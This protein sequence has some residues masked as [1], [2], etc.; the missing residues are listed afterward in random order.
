M[1]LAQTSFSAEIQT[2]NS[3]QKAKLLELLIANMI[4]NG[5]G[6]LV[7]DVLEANKALTFSAQEQMPDTDRAEAETEPPSLPDSTAKSDAYLVPIMRLQG[8]AE[9]QHRA[10][11]SLFDDTPFG[12]SNFR[13]GVLRNPEARKL[14]QSLILENGG[15]CS[16]SQFLAKIKDLSGKVSSNEINLNTLRGRISNWMKEG[17]IAAIPDVQGSY[18]M[19]LKQAQE[20]IKRNDDFADIDLDALFPPD[21]RVAVKAGTE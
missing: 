16:F 4:E 17:F 3:F 2:L 6:D 21:Q 1:P 19:T 10:M 12:P 8:L 14:L 5:H 13:R 7:R 9:T 20:T 18:T 15:V 11:T